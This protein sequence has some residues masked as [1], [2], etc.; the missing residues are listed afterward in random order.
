MLINR[1]FCGKNSNLGANKV[2][3]IDV[4]HRMKKLV[5]YLSLICFVFGCK[6]GIPD[7]V[8]QPKEMENVLFDIHI[9]DGYLNT[10]PAGDSVKKVASAY[11]KGVYNKYGIDSAT[12]VRS[13]NYYYK[14]TDLF[15]EMYTRILDRLNKERDKQTKANIKPVEVAKPINVDSV[16]KAKKRTDSLAKL[17]ADSVAAKRRIDSIFKT[18][19]IM[20]RKPA[21][22]NSASPT[23]N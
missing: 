13:K 6:A 7:D 5:F 9:V 18:K 4:L 15:K 8:L 1:Y 3:E 22:T 23:L 19:K 20:G 21:A 17:K 10:L 12:Y 2:K 16:E 14:R 11:Y